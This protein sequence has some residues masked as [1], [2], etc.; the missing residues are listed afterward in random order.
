M[1]HKSKRII[2]VMAILIFILFVIA[3]VYTIIQK[4]TEIK[5]EKSAYVIQ[6]IDF[7]H[8]ISSEIFT[9]D[10]KDTK[11]NT[12]NNQEDQKSRNDK[13]ENQTGKNIE[14]DI[15]TYLQGPKSWSQR[16]DWSGSWS[17]EFYDGSSFGAFGCGLCCLAN[18]YSTVS[19]F[20]CTP[21]DIYRFAKRNTE[22]GGGGAIAWEYMDSILANLGIESN[23]RRKPDSYNDFKKQISESSCSIVLVSSDA[24]KCYW[25]NTPGHY[26]TIFLYN[27]K[28]DTV[29]LADSGD[30]S[31]NRHWVELRKIYKSLKNTSEWQ[32]LCV[33]NYNKKNDK[34]KHKALNGEWVKPSYIS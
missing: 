13:L 15:F 19:N 3:A 27:K 22:Y 5:N 12:K 32:Y 16:L 4:Y 11:S 21:V 23:L 2:Y 20:C 28:N 29:F 1:K 24:S 17:S 31:H 7:F 8:K 14:E 10:D 26:V 6:E 9:Q 34:W 25:T 33:G 30:P 18:V